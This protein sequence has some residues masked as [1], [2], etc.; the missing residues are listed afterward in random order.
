M[1][2]SAN[3]SAGLSGFAKEALALLVRRRILVPAV[4]LTVLLTA[5]NIVILH[6]LPPEGARPGVAF[7][8]AAFV[9]VA[10]LIVLAVAILRIL[11]DSPRPAWRPDAGF[12]L[13]VLTFVL[14][15]A[16]SAAARR[17]IGS[18]GGSELATMILG[19]IFVTLLTAPLAP[20]FTAL[21]VER[22]VPWRPAAWV[23]NFR[24]WLLP[25][26]V[27][28]LLLV[29]PLAALH[30]A[31]DLHLLRGAGEWF[32]PLALVD[33]PIS[34]AIAL[35]SLALAAAAYRRVAQG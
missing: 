32:W 26:L 33:G 27:W 11:A 29:S 31:I 25:L 22:P 13:Y 23:R 9:R 7:G 34:A 20:W 1:A 15:A 21:A 17:L 12:W 6:N 24:A 8:A 5:S 10:G 3:E 35:L 16:L 28:M 2:T 14:G 30:G 18:A 4:V 19:G